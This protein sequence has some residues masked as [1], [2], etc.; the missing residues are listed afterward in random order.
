M[1]TTGSRRAVIGPRPLAPHLALFIAIVCA[2]LWAQLAASQR[3]A[4]TVDEQNH[5]ARGL[6]YL[7][8]GDLRLWIGHPPLINALAALPLLFDPRIQVPLNDPTWITPDWIEFAI[9]LFWK[10]DNPA[11]AMIAASRLM[12]MLLGVLFLAILYRLG[13]DLGGRWAGVAAV[14]LAAL[15]PNLRAHSRLVTT[16][17]GILLTL[18][19]WL[20]RR[21][22]RHPRTGLMLASGVALGL[23][24]ASK[25]SAGIFIPPLVVATFAAWGFGARQVGRLAAVAALAFVTTWA[26]YLF[27]LRPAFGFALPLPMPTY[28]EEFRWATSTLAF[29]NYLLGRVNTT[30]Y[31]EYF[32]I[33]FAVKTPV[34]LLALSAIGLA[35]PLGRRW[36]AELAVWLTAGFY[37]AVSVY[38]RVNIGYR[39]LF[40]IL[41]LL[42][43]AGALALITLWRVSRPGRWAAGGLLAWLALNTLLIYPRDLTFF[44]ELAGGPENGWRITVDSNLDWGQ[45]LGEL[46]DFVRERKIDSIFVSYFGSVPIGSVPVKEFPLPAR[47]L[48]PRPSPEYHPMFPAPGW[49]AISVTHLVGGASF[50]NSDT[51]A[52]FRQRQPEAILGR[53]IYVYHV[54]AETGTVAVCVNPPPTMSDDEVRRIFGPALTRLLKFDCA[55]G[56]PLPQGRAWYVLRGEQSDSVQAALTWLGAQLEYAETGQ[57]DPRFAFRLYQLPDAAARAAEYAEERMEP[58]SFGGLTAFL[59]HRYGAPLR[60]G[61]PAQIQTIWRIQSTLPEPLSIFLHLTAPDG[62]V[63]AQSDGFNTPF[64][65]LRPHDA[66]IQF[67]PLAFPADLPAGAQFQ[68]GVYALSGTQARYP[69]PD[70][71]DHVAFSP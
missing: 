1:R 2:F 12:I 66:L 24:L 36:R 13:A 54:P 27:E 10:L 56:L 17:L 69:L 33:V 32:P 50:Y 57:P 29:P 15:D 38:S 46:V 47:G 9:T 5:I 61:Q 14:A 68:I 6:S 44:N 8:T 52:Y 41:P 64:D 62:F 18:T 39:H 31:F 26:V 53:T 45:D 4:P 48:P 51:F 28:L 55:Q 23:A 7:V 34:P 65:S 67:H 11:L 58:E 43:I 70:G 59:G 40:P 63:L 49:Y 21:W 19:V 3:E 30:G 22:L 35:V 60:P 25:F 37:F 71:A 42:Y 20:W 16:D